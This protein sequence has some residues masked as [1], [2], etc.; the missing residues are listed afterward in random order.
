MIRRAMKWNSHVVVL[1]CSDVFAKFAGVFVLGM[2][3]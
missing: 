3:E 2:A 1:E